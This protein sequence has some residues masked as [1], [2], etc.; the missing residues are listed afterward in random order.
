MIRRWGVALIKASAD[1]YFL[2][3]YLFGLGD[4]TATVIKTPRFLKYLGC[5][6]TAPKIEF[7]RK[8]LTH[9]R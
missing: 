6:Q 9:G 3:K 7:N 1:I 8:Q 2:A 5:G 4:N